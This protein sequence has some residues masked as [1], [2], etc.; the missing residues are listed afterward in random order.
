MKYKNV[1]NQNSSDQWFGPECKRARKSFHSAK[2]YYL[3]RKTETN[4]SI[5][6]EKSKAYKKVLNK[7]LRKFK[8]SKVKKLRS[9]KTK[10]PKEY[11]KILN[12]QNK[13][14][15]DNCNLHD[16][17]KYFKNF[18]FQDSE[19][20]NEQSFEQTETI[21]QEINGKITEDE[22]VNAV[23]N[24]KN[25]KASG[26]DQVL[27]EHI[28]STMPIMLNIYEKLFNLILDTG[29][30]PSS[31]T[32][33]IIKPVYKNKG[34]KLEPQNFRPITLVSCFSKLFTSILNNRLNT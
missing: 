17:F 12:P 24:L 18:N 11:W 10:N 30:F 31:W 21:N 33:G 28:K 29:C 22:I 27:N 4:K 14:T 3:K 13:G 1:I 2:Y 15:T 9:L 23:K 5:L 26:Y 6:H 8:S 16:F 20:H 19:S 7:H 34:N 25:N 32:T